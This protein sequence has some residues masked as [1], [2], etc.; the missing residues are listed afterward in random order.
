MRKVVLTF[1]FLTMGI[2]LASCGEDPVIPTVIE[3][4]TLTDLTGKT[5]TEI[6]EIF[7]GIDL[8]INFRYIPTDS[9][10]AGKFI[11][12][13]SYEVGDS[14]PFGT[15]LRIEIAT[16]IPTAPVIT[17][18][19]DVEVFVS[20]TGNPPTFDLEEGVSATDYLG[21]NIPWGAFLS[22]SGNVD[23]YELGEYVVTYTAVHSGL[24][25]IVERVISIIVPPFDTN[26]TDALRLTASYAG[27]SFINQGIGE[28]EVTTFTDA[29]TTNFK[30]LVSGERFTVRYLGVDAPEATS[31]YDPWGIKAA[32]F[33]RET[34]SGAEK[35]ILEAETGAER[36]DGN[37]RY[38]AW[39]WYV[40]DGITRLLNL[41]LAEQAYAWVSGASSTQYGTIF[42]IA[43]A[44]TQMTGR[45]VYGEIDPDY[46]YSSAGTPIEIGTLIDTFD[47]YIG[48][49]VTITGVITSKV[50]NSVFIEQDGRG[51]YL[52]GGYTMTNELVIGHEVTIQGLVPAVY[53]EGKQLSN[54]LYEN[55]ILISTGN[56]VTISTILGS[57]I[58][59]YVGRVVRFE[60]LM[61]TSII[62][63][64]STTDHAYT[65]NAIDINNTTISIRV[66]DYT[67]AFIPSYLFIVGEQ[68]TVFGPVTQYLSGFQLMLPGMGNIVF[69]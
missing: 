34:L 56:E 25:T 23:Y 7:E 16:Q 47:L 39:V 43:G 50:G 28:V 49:K 2:F 45:R 46:D 35:I 6:S 63:S 61:I 20:V 69:E 4:Y 22:V 51:I 67:A 33:V 3:E 15:T 1:L 32:T 11:R 59:Q 36:T 17:G 26:H 13:V 53:F 64:A 57:Q 41:E 65:V 12:Y 58:G 24:I 27:L 8:V 37:G 66:D 38:L 30:D 68:I 29:D 54:Y 21:N 5:E 40:K 9:V 48:K 55:M 44:E 42:T 14:I 19:D 31:K 62:E 60:D 52:Y 18:A 10:A